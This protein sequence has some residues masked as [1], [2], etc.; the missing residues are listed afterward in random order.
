M[1]DIPAVVTGALLSLSVLS[2][3]CMIKLAFD[4]CAIEQRRALIRG[5][6]TSNMRSWRAVRAIRGGRRV[7]NSDENVLLLPLTSANMWHPEP[8]SP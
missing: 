8:K 6:E 4:Q 1:D 3:L 2:V 5:D 7:F